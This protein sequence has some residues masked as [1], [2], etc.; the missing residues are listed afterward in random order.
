MLAFTADVRP[1]RRR[2]QPSRRPITW[3]LE[4]AL[5]RCAE[6]LLKIDLTLKYRHVSVLDEYDSLKELLEKQPF[7]D[8]G[9]ANL[10]RMPFEYL[11]NI[12]TGDPPHTA[13]AHLRTPR[14]GG[15]GGAWSNPP[16][17]P[18]TPAPT[19]HALIGAANGL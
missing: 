6:S 19:H 14:Q 15:G 11:R 17:I 1:P 2:P 16:L 4:Y 7:A 8:E 5:R 18:P 13:C 10:H 9:H 12:A 3:R